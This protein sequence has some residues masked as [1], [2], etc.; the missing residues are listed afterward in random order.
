MIECGARFLE[1]LVDQGAAA[2]FRNEGLKPWLLDEACKETGIDLTL[3]MP[4]GYEYN[5]FFISYFMDD[6]PQWLAARLHEICAR[7]IESI[8]SVITDCDHCQ[9]NRA[10][11]YHG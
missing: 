4:E 11:G 10:E 8:Q 1:L 2:R 7:T 6:H 9:E 3:G 5:Y